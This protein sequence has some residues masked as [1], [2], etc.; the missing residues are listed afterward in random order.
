MP[1]EF[2]QRYGKPLPGFALKIT[3]IVR[4]FWNHKHNRIQA[5]FVTHVAANKTSF[6]SL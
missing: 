6:I 3:G 4:S 1:R 2:L 5:G